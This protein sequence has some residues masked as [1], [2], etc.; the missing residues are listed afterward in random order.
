M[1][2][3][4]V[5]VHRVDKERHQNC[6]LIL[7]PNCLQVDELLTDAVAKVRKAYGTTAG[8][9]YGTFQEDLVTFPFSGL[10]RQYVSKKISMHD[11]SVKS[12]HILGREMSGQALATGGYAFFVSYEENDKPYFMVILLKLRG[13]V[14]IDERA[15][16]LSK[17]FNLDIDHLHEAARINVNNWEANEGNYI[18]FVKKGKADANFTDYFRKF[19]GCAEFV[20]SRE[21][22][23]LLIKAIRDYCVDSQLSPEEAKKVKEKAFEYFQEQARDKKS[24]SLA[25]LSMRFNDEQPQAFLEYIEHNAVEISDG[26][27]PHKSTF[28][29]LKRVGGKDADLNI[30]FDLGLLGKRVLYDKI[31]K[32]LHIVDLPP[33]LIAQLDAE[34]T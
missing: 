29:Q 25:A 11:F 22:T 15:L 21:Q 18:S 16:T 19:L 1:L 2:I 7:K 28:R 9:A 27:E 34:M 31:K 17:N 32:E 3:K 10:L 8:R 30:N 26:F 12:M 13:G 20:E 14:G 4:E 33:S 5:I 23:G 24:I 6:T